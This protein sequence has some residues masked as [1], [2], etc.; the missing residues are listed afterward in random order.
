[1]PAGNRADF[2][3]A[4]NPAPPTPP[5]PL[6]TDVTDLFGG[7]STPTTTTQ[8]AAQGGERP[9]QVVQQTQDT[10]TDLRN[11]L[12]GWYEKLEEEM[13]LSKFTLGTFV[14]NNWENV[15]DNYLEFAD[16]DDLDKFL[17]DQEA[18][19]DLFG[20]EYAPLQDVHKMTYLN[21]KLNPYSL[22]GLDLLQ[23]QATTIM[24]QFMGI[25]SA[26]LINGGRSGGGGGYRGPTGQTPEQIRNQFDVD[27]LAT[28]A[29]DIWRSRLVA[30]AP[31]AR[32]LASSYVEAIVA[33][34][35]EKQIDFQEYVLKAA[36]KTPRWGL[37]YGD[38][39]PGVDEMQ[40]LAPYVAAAQ[41][42]IGG[43]GD[44]GQAV[45]EGA[46]LG[47]TTQDFAG[48]LQFQDTVQESS[49]FINDLEARMSGISNLLRG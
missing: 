14:E 8:P 27:A 5:A 20:P 13:G 21:G 18:L 10:R 33:S 36:R 3:E 37:L 4:T 29:N 25:D 46:G 12:E 42:A 16:R 28:S 48:K 7:G 35:G 38:K 47:A 40:Y 9:I 41:R 30:E 49:G 39:P 26:Q 11:F 22:A 19:V 6:P 31:N 17:A 34:G 43:Q 23:K 32:A 45:L 15:V 24:D 44:V 1:M 2:V